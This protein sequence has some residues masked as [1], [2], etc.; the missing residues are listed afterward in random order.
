[1]C[2][3]YILSIYLSITNLGLKY[4]FLLTHYINMVEQHSLMLIA[5][6]EQIERQKYI[7]KYENAF[8]M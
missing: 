7:K 6:H 8:C 5:K 2:H 3:V 4:I 1:M